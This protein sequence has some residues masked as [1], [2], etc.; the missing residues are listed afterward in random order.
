MKNKVKY[1]IIHDALDLIDFNRC[2]KMYKSVN[3]KWNDSTVPDSDDLRAQAYTL[4]LDAMR[5]GDTS[6]S[7][8]GITCIWCKKNKL[9][10]VFIGDSG[11]GYK[12]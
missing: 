7:C 4:S 5:R 12:R 3:W 2:A 8:G 11:E 10:L 6:S 1:Q 9:L